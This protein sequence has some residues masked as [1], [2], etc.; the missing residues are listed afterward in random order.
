M[1]V[2]KIIQRSNSSKVFYYLIKNMVV[3]GVQT[4]VIVLVSHLYYKAFKLLYS[5]SQ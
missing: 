4:W 5:S 2:F 1:P 3:L